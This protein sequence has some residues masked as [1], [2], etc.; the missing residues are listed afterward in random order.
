MSAYLDTL[1]RRRRPLG[2]AGH[3][4][5]LAASP[6]ILVGL[7]VLVGLIVGVV[8]ADPP[9]A[10]IR[11]SAADAARAG[12]TISLVPHAVA[13]DTL[14]EVVP[15][16]GSGEA[17]PAAHLLAVSPD[18][19]AAAL[20][21]R[22]GEVSG[23]L[24]VARAD[25]SQLR[26]QL[27]G[28]IAASF[29]ADGTWLAVIDG[30]GALWQVDT[31][32]GDAFT[33]A[34]GPFIGTPIIAADGSLLLLSVPSVEAPFQSRLV[35][36]V[37]ATGAATPLSSD[38]LVYAAF[39]LADGSV[40]LAAHEPGR[41]VVRRIG[42]GVG[43]DASQLLADLGPGA[44]NVAVSADAERIAFEAAGSGIF[45]IDRP[46]APPRSL[47]DGSSPCFAG[48]G[49]ALL[50]RRDGGSV[51]LALD[52]STLAFVDRPARFAGAA[53]CPS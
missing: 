53:G 33:L 30:R 3:V 47:G 41:T 2:G 43:V 44:V 48:G 49:S 52:G 11:L 6:L 13:G 28:L 9:P 16:A 29:A 25:G 5:S 35:R 19:A 14:L 34:E 38:E 8:S 20:A 46:G 45:L 51:A 21:D 1:P 36:F 27:P 37:P 23:S 31:A 39:A 17:G 42:V 7:V 22:I 12:S 4:A 32:S 18:G 26:V 40:A 15:A 50:V 10:V 24:T